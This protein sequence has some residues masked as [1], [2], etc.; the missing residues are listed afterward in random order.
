MFPLALSP[1]LDFS[2][3]ANTGFN[4]SF[5]CTY[6]E[7]DELHTA[8]GVVTLS[9]SNTLLLPAPTTGA[10]IVRQLILYNHDTGA[11]RVSF[12]LGG[13]YIADIRL[14]PQQTYTLSGAYDLR[15]RLN[16]L[17]AAD[18]WGTTETVVL[19]GIPS[20]SA[21]YDLI[22]RFFVFNSS[23]TVTFDI[24]PSYS[25]GLPVGA[26]FYVANVGTG[27]VNLVPSGS[28]RFNESTATVTL[29]RWRLAT[30]HLYDTNKWL[31]N[32]GTP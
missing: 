15:G 4:C 11:R 3:A 27:N 14:L 16:S 26:R 5:A 2:I 1:G 24:F 13:K 25:T 31:L 7:G 32:I 20:I 8:S 29:S 10:R 23:S 12:C 9:S 28:V 6:I 22:G 17:N 19:T 18:M 21:P 30:L